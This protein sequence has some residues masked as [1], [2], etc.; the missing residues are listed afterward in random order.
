MSAVI[1]ISTGR[2]CGVSRVCRVRGP[3]RASVYRD[4][5]PAQ[6]ESPRRA[7]A[8]D[9]KAPCRMRTWPVRSGRSSPTAG[10]MARATARCGRACATR[11]SAPHR[12]G[13]CGSCA[14]T[15][16]VRSH[17]EG[18]HTV[19]A[20][21]TGPSSRTVSTKGQGMWGTDMTATLP[22]TGRQVA[23]LVAVDHC[24]AGCVGV[25]AATRARASRRFSR[26]A[27]ACGNASGRS[28]RT[29]PLA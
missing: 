19:P 20:P 1:P 7:A 10:S 26:S 23:V 8:R 18:Q 15:G 11:G 29:W 2:T 27:R 25:H 6:A 9:Y 28:A 22:G 17:A 14:R 13:F 12:R 21:M 3:S 16:C 5:Q 24:P 4:L